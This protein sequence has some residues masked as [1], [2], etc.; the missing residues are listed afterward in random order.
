LGGSRMP[1][2]AESCPWA[3]KTLR[4]KL[5]VLLTSGSLAAEI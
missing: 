4:L 5:V 3:P 2:H 1:V